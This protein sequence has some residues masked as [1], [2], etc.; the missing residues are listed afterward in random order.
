MIVIKYLILFLIL[1][2]STLIGRSLSKKYVYRL[3]ELKEIKNS[4]NI[5]K[6]K[7][8]FTYEPIPELFQE[9][10]NTKCRNVGNIFKLAKEKMENENI[11]TA[12][13]NAIEESVTN[14]KKE[15]KEILKSLGKLLGRTDVEGQMGQIET[16]ESLLENQIKEALE[17]KLKNEKLYSRLGTTIGL[18][19][20][21]LLY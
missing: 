12:W 5:L 17:E 13:E 3:K 15:D 20:V 14:L 8:K 4:F 16:T 10:E 18:A 6:T 11:S 2:A 1:V 7:I 9:L 19:I 21:I